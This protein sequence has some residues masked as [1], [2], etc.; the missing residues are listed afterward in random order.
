MADLSV[1]IPARSEIFLRHTVEDVLAAIRGDTEILVVVDGPWPAEPLAV[2]PRVHVLREPRPIGQRAAV[3]LGAR[4][5]SARYVMKLDA[6][7]AVAPGFDVELMRTAELLGEDVTQ[8]PKQFNLHAFDWRCEAC[9]RRTYQGPKR[10]V[11]GIPAHF[12]KATQAAE[13]KACGPGCGKPGPFERV[14]VWDAQRRLTESWAF[15][16][17]LH[18]Q[19]AGMIKDRA[20]EAAAV[21][22]QRRPDVIET[23]SC[24]G[25]C[26]FMSRARHVALGG[27]D[28]GHGSWGQLG[29]E[30]ACKSWLSGGR[31]VTNRRTWYS[32][33]FRT[34]GADF[35]FP[36]PL[37]GAEVDKAR[38]Y[39]RALW[40]NDA[41]PGQVRPLRWLV[42]RFLPLPGLWTPAQAAALPATLKERVA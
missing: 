24:L 35:S 2:H 14:I 37:S 22:L 42:E 39:S 4:F 10:D 21:L 13:L 25:A 6:H 38:A 12:D 30:I 29:T 32:H 27:L 36:Y 8:I 33:M 7:C 1:I 34:Q 23:M 16:S 41:W 28:E 40:M 31:V 20:D 9:G 11:C 17:A 3:N 15:D 19:Y 26:W 5:S 18:F